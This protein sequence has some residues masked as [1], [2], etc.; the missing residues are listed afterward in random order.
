M[1]ALPAWAAAMAVSRS[2]SLMTFL[3]NKSIARFS[4]ASAFTWLA[5]SFAR[6]PLACANAASNGR[7]ID[8]EKKVALFYDAA[9]LVVA[10]NDVTLNLRVDVGVDEAVQRR[11]AFEH[12]RHILRLH[13]CH[14]NFRRGRSSLRRLA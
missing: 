9:L 1:F 12:A 7:G 4:S 3:L 14:E 6:V 2:W 13:S 8:L 11:D 10:R 5:L